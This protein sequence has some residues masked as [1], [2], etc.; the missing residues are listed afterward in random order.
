MDIKFSIDNLLAPNLQRLIR[1]VKYNMIA[2]LQ[3]KDKLWNYALFHQSNSTTTP[4]SSSKPCPKSTI[5]TTNIYKFF[6]LRTADSINK[7]YQ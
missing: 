1:N 7:E 3:I 4:S 6:Q 2:N 5:V